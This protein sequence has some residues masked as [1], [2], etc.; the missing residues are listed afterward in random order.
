VTLDFGLTEPK[1]KENW[2][3]EKD[4]NANKNHLVNSG[5]NN[6]H[7]W[8]RHQNS[9]KFKL[10]LSLLVV[11][12][13]Q[14][15]FICKAHWKMA[16][17]KMLRTLNTWDYMRFAQLF[18]FIYNIYFCF[19]KTKSMQLILHKYFNRITGWLWHQNEHWSFDLPFLEV[20]ITLTVTV[21]LT[22]WTKLYLRRELSC[23]YRQVS[24]TLL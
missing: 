10:V 22:T 19:L 18:L 9:N 5:L 20:F 15:I 24:K 17:L 8:G 1:R 7:I 11:Q 3:I 2:Q 4:K 23:S 21:W 6:S 12:Y 14:N 13:I 16:T